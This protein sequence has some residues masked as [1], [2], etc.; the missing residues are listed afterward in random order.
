MG[1]SRRTAALF[2]IFALSSVLLTGC[3]AKKQT[4][5]DYTCFDTVTV[6]TGYDTD[7]RFAAA[8]ELVLETL[9]AYHRASDIYHEYAEINNACT[10]NAAAGGAALSVPP[11]LMELLVFGRTMAERTN[12]MCNIAMGAVLAL[13]HDCREA[14]LNGETAQLPD[15]ASLAAAA[16]HCRMEDIVL[17]EA[18]GTARLADAE[19]RVDL[20]AVAKGYAVE[21]AAQK[22]AAAGYTG[23]AIS[24]GGNVRTV[25]AKPSGSW[26]AG[27]QNPDTGSDIPYLLRVSLDDAA[28]VTSGVY[29]RYY[30]VDG[31]RYHHILSPE[32]LYPKNDFLSVTIRCADSGLADALST[33]VFNMPFS[34]G[35]DYVNQMGGVEACWILADGTLRFSDGF[36]DYI[37][38]D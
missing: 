31:V 3:G 24:A 21:R 12:G 17:D 9:R 5:T 32:T 35:L 6:I 19:M 29:Q 20:G 14:A 15:S 1:H 36:S 34:D 30:E 27:I 33:A 2:L 22:L 8:S 7:E 28:L 38:E 13:W 26:I 18:A 11:E 37:L 4:V 10:L 23:Y 25:G 16:E